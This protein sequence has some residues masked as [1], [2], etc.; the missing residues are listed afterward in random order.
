SSQMKSVARWLSKDTLPA[1]VE[2]FEKVNIWCRKTPAGGNGVFVL[3]SS[4]DVIEDLMIHVLTD[5]DELS[6]FDMDCREEKAPRCG[7]S[8]EYGE[9]KIRNLKPWTAV[10]VR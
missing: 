4:F 2:S 3:N 8:G 5:K 10:L 6:V 7:D 1:Y 9:F